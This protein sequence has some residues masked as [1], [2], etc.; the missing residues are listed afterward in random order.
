MMNEMNGGK[1]EQQMT[2]VTLFE[3]D[4]HLGVGALVNSL[5]RAGFRGRIVAGFRGALPPWTQQLV[6][7]GP[8]R[9]RIEGGPEIEF[10]RL[11]VGVHFTNYKP[12]FLLQ[13]LNEGAC[14]VGVAYFDPDITLCCSWGFVEQWT[15]EGVALCEDITNG[16][17]P[18]N[19]PLRRQWIRVAQASSWGQPKRRLNRYY[20][21][22][23]VALRKEQRGF[24]ETWREVIQLTE[25]SG[26]KLDVFMPGTRE[27]SFYIPDQDGLNVTCMYSEEPLSTIGPEGMGFVHGGFTMYHSAGGSKPWRKKFLRSALAG[28]PPWNGDK[29]FLKMAEGPIRIYSP[30][31]LTQRRL[32][33][34]L[35]SL[36]GRFYRRR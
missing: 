20:N 8:D 22:G 16:T 14:P 18:E 1:A 35:A 23:F 5:A 15:E 28:V 4:Y 31:K 29:H 27:Q 12:D 2:V 11:Q 30:R 17:M 21:A 19:H 3:G 25:H 34:A 32:L 7:L 26:T 13:L 9:F 33:C 24:L 10:R 6:A 36:I